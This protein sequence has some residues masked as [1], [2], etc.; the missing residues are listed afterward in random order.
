MSMRVRRIKGRDEEMKGYYYLHM[1]GDLIWKPEIVA[2]DRGYFDSPFVEKVW[3]ID[4]TDRLQAWRFLLEALAAGARAARVSELADKWGCNI[5]DLGEYLSRETEI[6]PD[7][8]TGFERLC[9]LWKLDWSSY[10]HE[11]FLKSKESG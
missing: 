11:N 3:F 7:R 2:Q 5:L 1:N 6:T 10:G 4:T 8:K 9:S